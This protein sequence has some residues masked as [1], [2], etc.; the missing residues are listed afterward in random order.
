MMGALDAKLA[1]EDYLGR[2]T[3]VTPEAL[4]PCGALGDDACDMK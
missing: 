2:V 1:V 4:Q 3:Q